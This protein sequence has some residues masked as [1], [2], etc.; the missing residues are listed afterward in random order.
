MFFE[1][2]IKS[3]LSQLN[4]PWQTVQ[5][6]LEFGRE[7]GELE[8]KVTDLRERLTEAI[9]E[10]V[11]LKEKVYDMKHACFC[12]WGSSRSGRLISPGYQPFLRCTRFRL[13]S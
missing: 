2:Q 5:T 1:Y 13:P 9:M 12:K 4:H 11:K 3:W 10:N 8:A 6:L 7:H